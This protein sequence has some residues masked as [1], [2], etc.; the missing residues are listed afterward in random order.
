MSILTIAEAAAALR[1][2]E[3]RV[4]QW[5]RERGLALVYTAG[6]ARPGRRGAKAASL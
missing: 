2:P 1:V 4:W 5:Y 3:S 6:T